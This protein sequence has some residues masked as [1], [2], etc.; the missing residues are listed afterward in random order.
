M[1]G[2]TNS[3]IVIHSLENAAYL[4]NSIVYVEFYNL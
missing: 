3:D 4:P 1:K 2:S